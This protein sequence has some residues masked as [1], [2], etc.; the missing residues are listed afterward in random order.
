MEIHWTQIKKKKYK[1]AHATKLPWKH[2][3]STNGR[4]ICAIWKIQ[5]LTKLLKCWY[6]ENKYSFNGWNSKLLNIF[7]LI[8]QQASDTKRN[9]SKMSKYFKQKHIRHSKNRFPTDDIYLSFVRL[10]F[11]LVWWIW[12]HGCVLGLIIACIARKTEIFNQLLLKKNGNECNC[13]PLTFSFSLFFPDL[14]LG[15]RTATP[16][17]GFYNWQDDNLISKIDK[18][19]ISI[20]NPV[21]QSKKKYVN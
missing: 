8:H 2:F 7:F 20:I 5:K 3:K 13:L 19:H 15:G 4:K 10:I 12:F 18:R 1:M 6:W 14:P 16:P 9:G 11:I 21:D 17:I